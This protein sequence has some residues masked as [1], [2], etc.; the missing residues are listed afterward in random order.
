MADALLGRIKGNG[1]AL[2]NYQSDSPMIEVI[3]A[4]GCVSD[5]RIENAD[6]RASATRAALGVVAGQIGGGCLT[7]VHVTGVVEGLL[8]GSWAG[9]LVGGGE[10]PIQRSSFQ[11]IVN[12]PSYD[13]V[14]GLLGSYAGWSQSAIADSFA[15][16][17]VGG[18]RY[19]AGTVSGGIVGRLAGDGTSSVGSYIADSYAEGAYGSLFGGGSFGRSNVG[20]G[21]LSQIYD[22]VIAGWSDLIWFKDP[23]Q[24]TDPILLG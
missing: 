1:H 8:G 2:V 16:G 12:A 7:N 24:L 5:L 15:T 10:G 13:Q 19:T 14:G 22:W 23:L 18:G 21:T 17:T 20:V 3:Q 11:G 4:T 9:G 6:V